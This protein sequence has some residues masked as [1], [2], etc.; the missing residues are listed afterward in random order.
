M[1]W[2]NN[3]ASTKMRVFVE[4]YPDRIIPERKMEKVSV[5]GRN[6]D[7][8]FS[9]DAF[10]NYDQPYDIY[11]S[12][13]VTELPIAM[14]HVTDWLYAKG[15]NRLEDSYDP[16]TFRLA[17][18]KGPHNLE[19]IFNKFG[20]ATIVFNCRPERFLKD[21]EFVRSF[22]ESGGVLENPTIFTAKP[23]IRVYA[24]G[25]CSFYVGSQLVT[26]LSCDTY[27]DIDCDL[28]D[29]YKGGTNKNNTVS[30][31]TGE[32][33]TLP[34]GETGISWSSSAISRIEVTPRWWTV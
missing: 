32:F 4:H 18:F 2:W 12:A 26:L 22:S 9:Q 11:V 24:S 33:P 29:C 7:I 19:N 15:Y 6:G 13:E 20:R 28:Q 3:V 30:F 5:P 25:G 17:V 23:L 16:D 14:H 31:G 1:I 8:I 10:E 21:G 27:V 34:E